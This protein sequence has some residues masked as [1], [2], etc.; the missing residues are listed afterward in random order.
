MVEQGIKDPME[1]QAWSHVRQ[2]GQQQTQRTA[3]LV[4]LAT[5]NRLIENT[6]RMKQSPLLYALGVLQNAAHEDIDL[7]AGQVYDMFIGIISPQALRCAV[8]GH[9]N[10]VIMDVC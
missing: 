9:D 1:H 5:I 6:Q 3:Q 2:M 4:K 7:D 8:I 10:D